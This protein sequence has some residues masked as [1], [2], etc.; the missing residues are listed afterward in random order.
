LTAVG[1]SFFLFN[2]LLFMKVLVVHRQAS[3]ADHIKEHLP[4]CIVT[5]VTCG[6]VGLSEARTNFY[7]LVI[8]SN[9]LP[10]VTGFEMV[11]SLR[12]F[13]R[14]MQ[15][16]VILLAAGNETPGHTRL[17]SRL[18]ASMLTLVEVQKMRY[19]ELWLN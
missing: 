3:V 2:G 1:S 19:A 11:R 16:P 9:D 12:M 5:C 13:S 17:A 8:S 7:D 6:W 4:Q 14:N 18:N 10:V 15:V